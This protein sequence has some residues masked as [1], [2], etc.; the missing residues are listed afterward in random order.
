MAELRAEPLIRSGEQ[1]TIE[2]GTLYRVSGKDS[3]LMRYGGVQEGGANFSVQWG[4]PD[5]FY[6]PGNDDLTH[7]FSVGSE[8]I[9]VGGTV[10]EVEEVTP[11]TL[12]LRYMSKRELRLL[13]KSREQP[14]TA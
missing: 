7:I 14:E 4:R 2:T 10:F 12:K 8:R 13:Q 3:L 6:C 11:E 1:V 9:T 5:A